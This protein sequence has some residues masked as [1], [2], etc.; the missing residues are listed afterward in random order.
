MLKWEK[1]R[2]NCRHRNSFSQPPINWLA[3]LSYFPLSVEHIDFY[4]DLP[5]ARLVGFSLGGPHTHVLAIELNAYQKTFVFPKP[6][7]ASCA[8]NYN[9]IKTKTIDVKRELLF[10]LKI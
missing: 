2:L 9:H 1:V 3:R 8:C 6:I 4:E 5:N 10:L 7:Y